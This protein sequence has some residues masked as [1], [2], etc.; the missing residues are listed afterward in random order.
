[1]DEKNIRTIVIYVSQ[2]QSLDELVQ[3]R[4]D[5][6]KFLVNQNNTLNS[7]IKE[8]EVKSKQLNKIYNRN[9]S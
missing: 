7:K 9:Q 1:M 8:L 4:N 3:E 5:E 6:L 2:L